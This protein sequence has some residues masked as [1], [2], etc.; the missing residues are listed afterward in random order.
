[1]NDTSEAT[2]AKASAKAPVR[3][4]STSKSALEKEDA[5]AKPK[6]K[7]PSTKPAA[8]PKPIA[9]KLLSPGSALSRLDRQDVLFGTSSQLALDESPTTVRQIQQAMRE[10]EADADFEQRLNAPVPVWPRLQK[11]QGKRSLWGASARNEDGTTLERQTVYLPEPDRTQDFP[12]LMDGS[13]DEGDIPPTDSASK[14]LPKVAPAPASAPILISSDLPTPPPTIAEVPPDWSS[15]EQVRPTLSTEID[16]FTGKPPPSNQH[17]PLE[18]LDDDFFAPAQ[19]SPDSPPSHRPFP[20][21]TSVSLGSPKRKRGRPP[22]THSAIPQRVTASAPIPKKPPAKS[23]SS[24]NAPPTTPK[25]K[26]QDRFAVLQEILDSE[27][28]MALSPTPPRVRRLEDSPPL[29]FTT[30]DLPPQRADDLVPVLRIPESHLLFANIKPTLFTRITALVRSLPAT[31]NPAT[32]SWHE[33]ILMYDAIVLE[34]FT[35]FLNANPTI[36]TFRKATQK[37]IKA[38]NKDLKT[39]GEEKMEVEEGDGIVLATEKEVEMWM[40]RGWCEEMSVCCVE[41][42]KR[43]RGGARKGLY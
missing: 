35:A 21:R 3:K 34:D 4:R 37:Q 27:D 33:K 17:V 43:G 11:L 6:S 18:F 42:D 24:S 30:K 36:R 14:S 2:H 8:K 20:P 22:K 32:P 5:K 16:D 31:T 7:K 23:K 39:R 12:L 10:S 40:L 38:W 25:R 28:D 15:R 19:L 1:L 29:Q 9:E 41:R 13:M 26:S